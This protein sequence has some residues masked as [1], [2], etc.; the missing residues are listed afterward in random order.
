MVR[1]AS[2]AA[3]A[4]MM[5]RELALASPLPTLSRK[6]RGLLCALTLFFLA[7]GGQTTI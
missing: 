2:M 5:D 3:S 1:A 6:G 4:K 7:V